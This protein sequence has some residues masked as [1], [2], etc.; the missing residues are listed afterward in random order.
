MEVNNEAIK[1][2]GNSD[3]KDSHH[4]HNSL[5]NARVD[6]SPHL[7]MKRHSSGLMNEG[8][9]NHDHHDLPPSLMIDEDSQILPMHHH[10]HQAS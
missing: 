6:S 4:H 3:I 7:L 10:N 9:L 1:H 2:L 8:G 5:F